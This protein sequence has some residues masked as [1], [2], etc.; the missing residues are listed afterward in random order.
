MENVTRRAFIGSSAAIAA[1]AAVGLT[2]YQ[3][4][5]RHGPVEIRMFFM[6]GD[7][8]VIQSSLYADDRRDVFGIRVFDEGK[9]TAR[10]ELQLSIVRNAVSSPSKTTRCHIT[11]RDRDGEVLEG[12]VNLVAKAGNLTFLIDEPGRSPSPIWMGLTDVRRVL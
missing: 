2:A 10:A 9:E 8:I 3:G 7:P 1:G 12:D 5:R 6:S 4:I 11:T